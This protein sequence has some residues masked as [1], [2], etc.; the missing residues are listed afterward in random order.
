[1]EIQIMSMEQ[2][3][4]GT[5]ISWKD[6][7]GRGDRKTLTGHVAAMKYQEN[8]IREIVVDISKP[9]DDLVIFVDDPHYMERPI[10]GSKW[11]YASQI[12]GIG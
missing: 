5:P 7:R 1:M 3:E 2:I 6:G 12:I 10:R 9:D 4:I 8:P 11:F